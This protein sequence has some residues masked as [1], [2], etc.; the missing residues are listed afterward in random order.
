MDLE[1]RH[2]R[3]V[4]TIADAGSVTKAAAELGVAQPALTAQLGRIERALGGPLFDR[5]HRGVRTTPLGDLVVARARMLLPAMSG[6]LDDAARMGEGRAGPGAPPHL[7][8]GAS[9]ASVLAPLIRCLA[10][11]HPDM[12][13]STTAAWSADDVADSLADGR[14]DVA[15]VGVVTGEPPPGPRGLVW[16][17]VAVD[18]VFVLLSPDHPLADRSEVDLAEL[19]DAD[20]AATPGDDVFRDYFAHACARAGFTPGTLYVTDPSSCIDLARA[21]TAV[22]LCQAVR[23]VPDLV[24]MPLRGAPLS[25]THLVGWRPGSPVDPIVDDVIAH[26]THIHDDLAQASEVYRRWLADH[27]DHGVG[28]YITPEV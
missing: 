23:T 3:I 18:P 12:Q 8:V 7:A 17:T 24:T 21:G 6:L 4:C 26:V 20:W 22:V 25:W 15:L 1:L 28:P 14:L 5:D 2:L 19:A 11:E 9:T 13:V 27:P 16:H 10:E